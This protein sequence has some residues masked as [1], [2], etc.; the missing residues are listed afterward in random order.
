MPDGRQQQQRQRRQHPHGIRL[1][2]CLSQGCSVPP[3]SC[4]TPSPY[5][6]TPPSPSA[7]PNPANSFAVAVDAC[8]IYCFFNPFLV[9]LLSLSFL[10]VRCSAPPPFFPFCSRQHHCPLVAHHAPTARCIPFP[11]STFPASSSF[12]DWQVSLLRAAIQR[13]LNELD[14]IRN[15]SI[16]RWPRKFLPFLPLTPYPLHPT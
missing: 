6:G 4:S 9:D 2:I 5:A 8:F 1:A 16:L 3:L 15:A 7:N 12:G 10:L 13:S 11:P 14:S